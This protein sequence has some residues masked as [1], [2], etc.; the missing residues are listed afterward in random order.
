MKKSIK[1]GLAMRQ[2]TMEEREKNCTCNYEDENFKDCNVCEEY[3][4]QHV[5]EHEER[6]RKRIFEEQEY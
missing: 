1:L 4:D 2:M 5:E 3:C 6:K